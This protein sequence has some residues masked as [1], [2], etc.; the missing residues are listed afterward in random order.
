MCYRYIGY[1]NG[2]LRITEPLVRPD[3]NLHLNFVLK[4][5]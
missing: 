3:E 5:I 4:Y 1:R 2:M